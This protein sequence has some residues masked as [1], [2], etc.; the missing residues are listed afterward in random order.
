MTFWDRVRATLRREKVELDELVDEAHVVLD[1]K[2][3]ELAATPEERLALE[4]E[5]AAA[6]DAEFDE[7][8][9]RI[10]RLEER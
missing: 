4:Q 9:E 3:R 6:A 5:R 10:R 8:R 7:V 2:E 1:R